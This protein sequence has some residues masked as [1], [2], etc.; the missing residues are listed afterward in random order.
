MLQISSAWKS[1]CSTNFLLCRMS[2]Y[3]AERA[4]IC[5]RFSPLTSIH[6]TCGSAVKPENAD[7]SV[8][9]KK[10][11]THIIRCSRCDAFWSSV[12]LC[13]P[14]SS[15]DLT[16]CR[17]HVSRYVIAGRDRQGT[18]E[19]SPRKRRGIGKVSRVFF[20]CVFLL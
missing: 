20:F 15:D 12:G 11:Y 6:I 3:V 10:C 13:F 8:K 4:R 9:I 19:V 14:S 1:T 7:K 17:S 18:W 2:I 16:G 5:C